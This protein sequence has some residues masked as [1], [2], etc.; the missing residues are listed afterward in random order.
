[1][2]LR[3]TFL[4]SLI[5]AGSVTGT[6][7]GA[8]ILSTDEF[9]LQFYDVDDVLSAYITNSAYANQLILSEPFGQSYAPV[10]ISAYVTPGSNDI[11]LQLYNGPAGWTYGYNFSINGVSYDSGDCG[12]FN[13]YGCNNNAYGSGYVW[14]HD[15]T[16]DVV[17]PVTPVP[18]APSL[19]LLAGGL[20]ALGVAVAIRQRKDAAV[21]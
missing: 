16:F 8:P 1:M 2:K 13:V 9:A 4:L 20:F 10:D 14:S 15:I 18:E 19:A 12:T 3:T 5:F 21:A 6:A 7:L 11:F 17:E